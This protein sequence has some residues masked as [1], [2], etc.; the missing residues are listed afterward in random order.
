MTREEAINIVREKCSLV[1]LSASFRNALEVL[2]PEVRNPNRIREWLYKQTERCSDM[3]FIRD[4]FTK[5]S[6][7]AWIEEQKEQK[8]AEWSEEDKKMLE[9]CIEEVG[10][11]SI[12]GDVKDLRDWLRGLPT[13][14]NLQLKQEWS[15][16]DKYMLARVRDSIE[17]A[18][19][20]STHS[21]NLKYYKEELDWL[22][23]LPER[24][25]LPE[26]QVWTY[27]DIQHYRSLKSLLLNSGC[28][29]YSKEEL[30][31]WLGEL[32]TKYLWKPREEQMEALLWCVAHLGGADHRVLAELYEHL[33]KLM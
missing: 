10:S 2:I 32:S 14:F 16:E 17:I 18:K 6:V 26:K 19:S 31:N 23:D 22:K 27:E 1:T 4:G 25:N 5:E 28:V 3:T 20:H 13:R 24:F 9:D 11:M 30:A 12:R 8:P 7:L 21:E 15:E 29:S 33:K